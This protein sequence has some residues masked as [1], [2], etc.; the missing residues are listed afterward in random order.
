L[1]NLNNPTDAIKDF[2]TAIELNDKNY[3]GWLNRGLANAVG[4]NV[5][6]GCADLNKAL[7]L[8]SKDAVEAIKK[9]CK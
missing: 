2:T 5:K 3:E 8:G 1:I 7:A 4:Y 6:Q 9:Y